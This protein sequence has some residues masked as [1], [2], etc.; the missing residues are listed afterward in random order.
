VKKTFRPQATNTTQVASITGKKEVQFEQISQSQSNPIQS[1]SKTN[2]ESKS[3]SNPSSIPNPS[4]MQ[5][6]IQSKSQASLIFDNFDLHARWIS[7]LHLHTTNHGMAEINVVVAI[8]G[9]IEI[10]KRIVV[11]VI[12]GVVVS[13]AVAMARFCIAWGIAERKQIHV[14]NLRH[15]KETKETK[16]YNI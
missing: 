5:F 6:Q 3:K 13:I 7:T 8:I 16:S 14:V 9:S 4:S 15:K 12:V 10:R 1:N 2:S 11:V